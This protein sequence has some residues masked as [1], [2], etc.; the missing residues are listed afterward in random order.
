MHKSILKIFIL[1]IL[2]TGMMSFPLE[3][4][5]VKDTANDQYQNV[6]KYVADQMKQY[7]VPSLSLGIVK[8]DTNDTT[9]Y[10]KGFGKADSTG[11]PL[12]PQ[13]PFTIGSVSKS[14]TALAVMQLVELG[15]INLDDSINIYLPW[16]EAEYQGKS[17]VITVRQLLHHTS[18]IKSFYIGMADSSVTIEQLVQG[19]LNNTQLDTLPG[20]RSNY[21]N[22]NYI[23]LGEIIQS[24][25][26]QSYQDYI[27]E[28]IFKPLEMKHSY[29][30]KTDAVR[31]GLATGYQK[32]FGFPVKAD[33]PYYEYGLPEGY[34]IS[35]AEDMVHY[36]SALLNNGV[37]KKV[38]I[39]SEEGVKELFNTEVQEE[40]VPAGLNGT[41]SYYGF[42]WR[43]IYNNNKLLMIQ[44][45]G[46]T[47]NY[48]ANVVLKPEEGIGVIELDSLG[49]DMSPSSI[50]IGVA[51]IMTGSQPKTSHFINNVFLAEIIIVLLICLL[52]L[53][54]IFKLRKWK[55]R[56]GKSKGRCIYALV[57]AIVVNFI[58]PLL[59]LLFMPS[60][61]DCNWKASMLIY[62]DIDWT[63]LV[64]SIMLLSIGAVKLVLTVQYFTDKHKKCAQVPTA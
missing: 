30:S 22:A 12:T 35:C 51:D 55:E 25:T 16:F 29:V 27:T 49:G 46:E 45:T 64:I 58:I 59:T 63:V 48:H 28:K 11:K 26:G 5:A 7:H 15:Q 19:K 54:S 24:V 57:I 43:I 21:S 31:D 4:S 14:F 42:G 36:I 18:G 34:I 50:G 61:F 62:P 2:L 38:N 10:L 6:E 41:A 13:T 52:L 33:L 40:Y 9:V 17:Q 39:L 44:H 23:I 1:A 3:A 53:F 47:E 56:I 60:M 8:R 20:T 32:W 37:Y